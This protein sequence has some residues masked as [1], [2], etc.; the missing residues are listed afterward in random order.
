MSQ[1]LFFYP[2]FYERAV[3]YLEMDYKIN[4]DDKNISKQ[5]KKYGF[6]LACLQTY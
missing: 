1:S 5:F 4:I 3:I 6:F 2:K